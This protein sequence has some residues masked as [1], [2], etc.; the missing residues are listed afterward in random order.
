MSATSRP[1]EL[2]F[3]YSHADEP[4]RKELETHLSLLEREGLIRTWHDRDIEAGQEW[5]REIDQHLRTADIVLLLVSP[6]FIASR[7]CWSI[8]VE[9][10]L[11]RHRRGEA[12]V[13]PIIL[14]PVYWKPS[15]IG[16]LQALPKDAQPIIEWQHRDRA[17]LEVVLELRRVIASLS[18][19]R[20]PATAPDRRPSGDAE[21]RPAFRDVKD[22]I[23]ECFEGSLSSYARTVAWSPQRHW[24][25]LGCDEETA[26]IDLRNQGRCVW[27]APHTFPH[28]LWSPNGTRLG[29]VEK[30]TCAVLDPANGRELWSVPNEGGV[31]SSL[32]WSPD[33]SRL[34]LGKGR[35]A[36]ILDA[37]SGRP[38]CHIDNYPKAV[39]W[40]PTGTHL[41]IGQHEQLQLWCVSGPDA[42]GVRDL[43][44]RGAVPYAWSPDGA[45]L[46]VYAGEVNVIQVWNVQNDEP[47]FKL[48]LRNYGPR[49]SPHGVAW[50]PGGA[51]IAAATFAGVRIFGTD[52]HEVLL[53]PSRISTTDMDISSDG[54]Q[55]VSVEPS[56]GSLPMVVCVWDVAD[57]AT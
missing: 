3:S 26:V 40:S 20:P 14:R 9:E 53:L 16:S 51:W 1:L 6:S 33:G 7:Y 31:S 23:L 32:S 27:R 4:L 35:D 12:R 22:R 44:I 10:A 18:A 5:E 8:E 46:A 21:H 42:P 11:A 49:V 19:P 24:I 15:P 57:L 43:S 37:A 54:R 36:S 17:Y 25:A 30:A 41:A 52:G 2:F 29:V 47:H 48:Q 45:L 28:V 34:A 39:L 50:A 38:L 56:R 55:I 13:I